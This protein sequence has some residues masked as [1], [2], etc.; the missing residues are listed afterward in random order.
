ME[1]EGPGR[2]SA[3]PFTPEEEQ[4]FRTLAAQPDIYKKVASSIA[5]SIFGSN[6]E[7]T[8]PG[9]EQADLVCLTIASKYG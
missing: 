4:R 5:P 1:T 9:L 8:F 6:G 2:S 7:F 3:A